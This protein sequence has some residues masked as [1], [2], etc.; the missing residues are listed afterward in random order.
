VLLGG[1]VIGSRD[2]WWPALQARLQ[3]LGAP[4]LLRPA[5]LG[6]DAG[7]LGAAALAWQAFGASAPGGA[8]GAGA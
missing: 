3:A 8:S 5:T 1:G 7:M 2:A 6:N 4:L